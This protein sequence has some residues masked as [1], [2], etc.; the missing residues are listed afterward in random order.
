MPSPDEPERLDRF[1]VRMGWAQSRR[2][3][4]EL[5]ASGRVRI[6]GRRLRKGEMVDPNGAVEIAGTVLSNA[7]TPNF[8]FA[9]EILFEDPDVLVV[10]KPALYPCHPLRTDDLSTVMNGV[11]ACYPETALVGDKPFEGGLIH[12]LDNG[13]SGALIIARSQ[14]AFSSLRDAIRNNQIERH[15]SALAANSVTG[16]I[17]IGSPIAHHQKNPRRMIVAPPG[18]RSHA[19]PAATVVEAIEHLRGFTLL[20][21]KPRTGRRHQIRV[22]LASVGLPLAGDLL[23]GGPAL[24]E[25]AAGRFW[26]HLSAVAFESPASG[27]IEVTTPLPTDLTAVL[28]RLR[29]QAP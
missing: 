5:I 21:V 22:H 16:S 19:R 27:R 23:Y 15:Y 24:P 20:V 3:A 6:G 13:T 4:R 17:E 12:R 28:E 18:T 25:L 10:N 7:I 8:D 2:L 14:E 1:L 26:L 11:V 9:L 29:T